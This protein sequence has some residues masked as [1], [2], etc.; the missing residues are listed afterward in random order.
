[1]HVIMIDAGMVYLEQYRLWMN[2][3]KL[4]NSD[5]NNEHDR[6]ASV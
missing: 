5:S 3:I 2:I 4:T 1:M 6:K